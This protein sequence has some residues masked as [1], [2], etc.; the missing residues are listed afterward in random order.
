MYRVFGQHANRKPIGVVKILTCSVLQRG[1][2]EGASKP[3][4]GRPLSGCVSSKLL[5][6][7][8][9]VSA[10]GASLDA[11]RFRTREAKEDVPYRMFQ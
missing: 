7:F 2:R 6:D 10:R 1:A 8:T 4:F 5:R 11:I 3:T 9:K